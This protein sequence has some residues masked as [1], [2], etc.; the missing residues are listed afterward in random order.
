MH[1]SMISSKGQVTIP[2]AIR[3]RLGLHEG[4][5]VVFVIE[6]EKTILRPA[7][8]AVNPFEKYAGALPAFST[9][10]EINHW[11]AEMR[12]EDDPEKA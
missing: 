1:T 11:V 3:Q 12:D 9:R 4:D 6:G 7:A 10:D 2:L 8:S 5:R